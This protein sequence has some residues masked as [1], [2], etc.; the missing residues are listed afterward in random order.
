MSTKDFLL[1][2]PLLTCAVASAQFADRD[3]RYRLQ[4]NDVIE[5]QY[6][7]TPEY[8]Q[9]G[10]VNP[11]GF[12]SLQLLGAVKLAGLTLDEARAALVAQASTRLR[13]PEISIILKDFEKPHFVVIGEIAAPGRFELRGRTS[14]VEAIAL[15][16]GFSRPARNIPR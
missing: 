9:T 15:A 10:S 11:D 13:D 12:V 2:I 5:I 14:A 8:N 7:Y 1:A 4:P 16:G 6:R 3:V